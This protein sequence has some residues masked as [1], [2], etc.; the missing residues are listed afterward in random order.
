MNVDDIAGEFAEFVGRAR[1]VLEQQVTKAQKLVD[2]LNLEKTATANAL[3]TL[4]S[5]V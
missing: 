5:Q 1:A 2:S 3:V 4:Q